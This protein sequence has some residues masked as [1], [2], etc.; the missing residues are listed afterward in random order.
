MVDRLP[1]HTIRLLRFFLNRPDHP[2]LGDKQYALV[3]D[4][5]PTELTNPIHT[6]FLLNLPDL[7]NYRTNAAQKSIVPLLSSKI[8][9]S[10]SLPVSIHTRY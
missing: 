10:T 5:L 3:V 1:F 4:N 2:Q 6:Q 7:G 9:Y 8:P